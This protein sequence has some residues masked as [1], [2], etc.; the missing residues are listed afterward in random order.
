MCAKTK[1]EIVMAE[2]GGE[3]ASGSQRAPPPPPSAS[4]RLCRNVIIYGFCK[5]EDKG[6]V[7]QHPKV[8]ISVFHADY[9]LQSST[10]NTAEKPPSSTKLRAGSP[11]FQ[12]SHLGVAQQ[13]PA[14]SSRSSLSIN[15]QE[16]VPSFDTAGIRLSWQKFT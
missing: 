1:H 10:P 15:F 13:P 6:C 12:P 9:I 8:R 14:A 7:F 11:A 4:Q 16:F 2:E 5:F 3:V